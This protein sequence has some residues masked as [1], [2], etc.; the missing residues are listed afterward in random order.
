MAGR[1]RPTY[2]PPADFEARP[3]P[4]A[5]TKPSKW[6]RLHSEGFD[7]I[8]F[9]KNDENRYSAASAPHGAL[10][11]GAD[12]E[13]CL[14]EIYGDRIYGFK[15]KGE[16][17]V[18]SDA[19]WR[20]RHA[21]RLAVPPLKLCDFTDRKTLQECGVDSASLM[22]SDLTVPQ[23]WGSAVMAHPL[24]FDG[25]QFRSRFTNGLCLAIFERK[26]GIKISDKLGPITKMAEGD[27]LLD[28]FKIALI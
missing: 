27:H 14:M 10:Y 6:S 17:V 15:Q 18:L 2:W 11:V 19:D 16:P 24:Q 7:P 22:S 20:T 25:I 8:Y 13:T 3:I 26:R 28:R 12:A 23:A 9:S 5:S 4:V 21:T 1:S